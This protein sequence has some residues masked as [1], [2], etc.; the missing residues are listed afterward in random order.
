[1]RAGA[2]PNMKT[3]AKDT[4]LHIACSYGTGKAMKG[5]GKVARMLLDY[6]ADMHIPDAE[7]NTPLHFAAYHHR[8][9]LLEILLELMVKEHK[10]KGTHL[11]VNVRNKKGET[12][13]HK[14]A[15][16]NKECA[17]AT[18][19]DHGADMNI[20]SARGRTALAMA[21]INR[22]DVCAEL[23]AETNDCWA[24]MND[25]NSLC[26]GNH[27][28]H[29]GDMQK[30]LNK[31]GIHRPVQ[32]P[33]LTRDNIIDIQKLMKPIEK[34]QWTR[35][36]HTEVEKK[37]PNRN[38]SVAPGMPPRPPVKQL[39]SHDWDQLLRLSNDR[40]QDCGDLLF[41]V[42]L[43]KHHVF[44]HD[45]LKVTDSIEEV[46][47]E[48]LQKYTSTYCG[49][50]IR[51]LNDAWFLLHN[52]HSLIEEKN[53]DN[54]FVYT[55][56]SV[57]EM[58]REMKIE[59]GEDLVTLTDD[60]TMR[61]K[62]IMRMKAKKEFGRL[63]RRFKSHASYIAVPGVFTPARKAYIAKQSRRE[64]GM[65]DD[66][67]DEDDETSPASPIAQAAM[68]ALAAVQVLP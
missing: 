31:F 25:P 8:D 9:G 52:K 13:L 22:H 28:V 37:G 23:L 12:P 35:L 24:I 14:A 2:D 15:W 65:D 57:V 38:A 58:L 16:N 34:R 7:G 10:E 39:T 60:D 29:H 46:N 18:L 62:E 68:A 67:E 33:A 56:E 43:K 4:C 45:I 3:N 59:C 21:R 30:L 42:K 27:I 63:I 55:V 61:L 53:S 32:L 19:L 20:R 41:P 47:K 1:M 6:G 48:R 11:H 44:V 51:T 66:E 49:D 36:L 17:I 50:Y 26:V 54:T 40:C 64:L 5:K